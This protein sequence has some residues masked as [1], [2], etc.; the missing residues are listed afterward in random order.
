MVINMPTD[1]LR[2][3]ATFGRYKI[4]REMGRGGMGAVYEAQHIKLGKRFALKVLISD[5]PQSNQRERF[6]REARVVARMVHDNIVKV[7]DYDVCDGRP[8]LAM[9]YLEGE[10]LEAMLAREGVLAPERIAELIVPILSAISAAHAKGIVHRDLK[11]AN[12]FLARG[13]DGSVTP[14]VLDFGISKIIQGDDEA[15]LTA[16]GLMMGSAHYMSQEQAQDA[17]TADARSDQFS[18]GV[19]LFE[20]ATGKKP[21]DGATPLSIVLK[22]V[23]GRY[24]LPRVLRP[25]LLPRFEDIVVRAMQNQPSQRFPSVDA[26]AF[27]L[28]Y[29]LPDMSRRTDVEARGGSNQVPSV[30]LS[31]LQS[32]LIQ[33]PERPRLQTATVPLGPPLLPE[34]T[35]IQTAVSVAG[36]VAESTES[37]PSLLRRVA[38][39]VGLSPDPVRVG[40]ND[41]PSVRWRL[42]NGD[43]VAMVWIPP[44]SFW[45]GSDILD[46]ASKPRHRRSLARGFYAAKYPVTFEQFA[47]FVKA[48]RYDA[49]GAWRNPGFSQ[50]AEH[51][52]V[53]VNWHDA[54]E[55]CEWAGLRL[56]SEEEWEYAARG[57][58]GREYPW[59][60]SEPDDKYLW[61]SGN[62]IRTS[63][64]PV[65][66]YPAGMSPFG[67]LDMVGNAAE[68]VSDKFGRYG[69][70]A[71]PMAGDYRVYRGGGRHITTA[72]EAAIASRYWASPST[73]DNLV[74]FRC[75]CDAE[76]I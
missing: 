11:P 69:A 65:T 60:T 58:D 44:G 5:A 76:S 32:T 10:D 53:C 66:R 20:C 34:Q 63:T 59:G 72:R 55:Y 8:F 16:T 18:I 41:M 75:A 67:V 49:E 2:A 15:K 70:G 25:E 62:H 57:T 54:N 61:W 50:A 39:L 46:G 28:R 14:K 42:P 21:F 38:Q 7:S 35:P 17:K 24:V 19:I 6:L 9:E 45:M 4:I 26:L 48:T 23:D 73:F 31:A 68:W 3:G 47:A 52:V 12:I 56:L 40:H 13:S 22:I 33:W 30:A 36:E 37:E 64:C 71:E 29:F 51:P 27:E 1:D 43:S 74:G